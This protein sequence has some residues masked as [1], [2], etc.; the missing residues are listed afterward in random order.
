MTNLL[1]NDLVYIAIGECSPIKIDY[2]I[3]HH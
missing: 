3:T 1:H 2:L